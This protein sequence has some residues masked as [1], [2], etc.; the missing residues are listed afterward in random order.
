MIDSQLALPF[1][2]T[3]YDIIIDIFNVLEKKFGLLLNSKQRF[4][5]LGSG[6]G[7][8]ILY[9]ALHYSISSTG[10]EID[11][12]LIEETKT[13][14]DSLRKENSIKSKRLK[15]IQ[16]KNKDFFTISLKDY[17]YVYIYSLPTMQ[18]FLTHL[19]QTAKNG[20]VIVSH[21]YPLKGFRSILELSHTLDSQNEKE[22]IH[23]YFHHRV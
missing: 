4:I 15:H 16:V 5:D 19:F 21:K 2:E 3:S 12:N 22:I 8:I 18:R 1:Q 20:A 10:F 9:S 7:Q 17:D 13:R 6:N 14:I 23:T 11:K